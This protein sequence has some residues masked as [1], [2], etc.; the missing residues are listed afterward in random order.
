MHESRTAGAGG[1]PRPAELRRM[2]KR[3]ACRTNPDFILKP[4]MKADAPHIS[5]PNSYGPILMGDKDE[6]RRW[7]LSK[8]MHDHQVIFLVLIYSSVYIFHV[9]IALSSKTKKYKHE[10]NCAAARTAAFCTTITFF[11]LDILLHIN[12][13][14]FSSG[15]KILPLRQASEIFELLGHSLSRTLTT[16]CYCGENLLKWV[17][18]TTP[19]GQVR[20]P[21]RLPAPR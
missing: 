17:W 12:Y 8:Q 7:R 18:R 3:T 4:R 14:N 11:L 21:A 19:I 13:A 5:L 6:R 15:W 1:Q 2:L 16:S 20:G 9:S 10:Y